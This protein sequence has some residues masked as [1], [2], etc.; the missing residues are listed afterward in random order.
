MKKVAIVTALLA[1]AVLVVWLTRGTEPAEPTRIAGPVMGTVF[2]IE[3]L[4][5]PQLSAE[6][7]ELA[8]RTALA[9]ME[10]VNRAMSTYIDDSEISR[11]S[12][13]RETSP[14]PI[15]EQTFFVIAQALE[16]ARASEG[17]FD[18][19]V[20]P[21]VEL[22]GFGRNRPE[23]D[24]PT[25]DQVSTLLAT[26]GW[27]KL[28]L[29]AATRTVS[30]TAPDLGI[31]LSGIAKGYA[32]DQVRQALSELGHQNI[33]VE[34]GGEVSTIGA[35]PN[36]TGWRLGIERPV[37]E[38]GLHRI[39]ELKGESALATSGEY[40]NFYEVE[41]QRYSHTL[42]PRTGY[43]VSHALASVS[44]V[45]D[46]CTTA[47]AWATALNVLGPETGLEIADREKIAALFLVYNEDGSLSEIR[48]KAFDQKFPSAS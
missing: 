23:F 43:P 13:S 14:F 9:A 4:A 20:G 33:M 28:E 15:S 38:G 31:N 48:S 29:D 40:R 10:A 39:V 26:L 34:I 1:V 41:G 17:A 25:G 18:V 47:D 11:F 2:E 42:D 30:K 19:T 5:D 27:Q 37:A 44:V 7:K 24:L 35:G 36:G 6:Q 3:I 46:N 32:A 12:T 22:W 8:E 21:L 16:V 45:A